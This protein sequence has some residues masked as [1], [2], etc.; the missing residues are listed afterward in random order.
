VEGVDWEG[1]GGLGGRPE[2]GGD[3]GGLEGCRGKMR[4]RVG[5]VSAGSNVGLLAL[6]SKSSFISSLERCMRVP[7]TVAAES[8]RSFFA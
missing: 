7:A 4:G 1:L 2:G 3:S 5:T 8:L 6:H